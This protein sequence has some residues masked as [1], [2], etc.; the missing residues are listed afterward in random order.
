MTL[1]IRMKDED[2]SWQQWY[3]ENPRPRKRSIGKRTHGIG[4]NDLDYIVQVIDTSTKKQIPIYSCPYYNMWE[5]MIR[6]V[7]K[8]K[9]H[10]SYVGCSVDDKFL[11]AKFFKD[12]MLGQIYREDGKPLQLDKDI[13][14][15]GNR[16][17]S[18]ETCCF[19]PDFVNYSLYTG[20]IITSVIDMIGANC[21]VRKNGD[22][23]YVAIEAKKHL[24]VFDTREAAHMAWQQ[25]KILSLLDVIKKYSKMACFREDVQMSLE[26]RIRRI[27]E[28]IDSS[29]KTVS[30]K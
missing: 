22:I 21:V 3:E 12:W 28:D 25:A 13:L 9:Q 6:R 15:D 24:G 26:R 18:P 16:V 23:K 19:V 14:V 5:R 1:D 7:T 11:S 20:P 4:I 30:L 29:R 2:T 17:Y 27:Q 10:P 8:P